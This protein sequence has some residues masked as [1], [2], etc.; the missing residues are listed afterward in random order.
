MKKFLRGLLHRG[1]APQQPAE[2]QSS[3]PK[4]PDEPVRG[5]DRPVIESP[6]VPLRAAARAGFL[7]EPSTPSEPAVPAEPPVAREPKVSVLNP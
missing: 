3:P 6:P 7:F 2:E 4:P 1:A 5:A